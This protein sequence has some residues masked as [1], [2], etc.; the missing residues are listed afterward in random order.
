MPDFGR[1]INLAYMRILGRPADPGGQEN[2]DQLMNQGMSE[3]A[4]RETLV[5]SEEYAIKNPDQAA[6]AAQA[7]KTST[8]ASVKSKPSKRKKSKWAGSKKK[9]K[10]RKSR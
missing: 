5:R 9:S 3:A 1:I 2:F 7:A 10:T 8:K 4:M 6:Q